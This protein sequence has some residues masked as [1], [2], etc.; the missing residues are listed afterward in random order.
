[1]ARERK[2]KQK[3]GQQFNRGGD[4]NVGLDVPKHNETY[5]SDGNDNVLDENRNIE[6]SN[7]I[8]NDANN[9]G[10]S[11]DGDNGDGDNSDGIVNNIGGNDS[12]DG[13]NHNET[14]SG[15]GNDNV[16]G[17]NRKK[18][19]KTFAMTIMLLVRLVMVTMVMVTTVIALLTI[20]VALTAMML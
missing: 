15:N 13:P 8:C 11:C 5:C 7:D 3:T 10:K 20:L 4:D 1:M 9:V 12:S 6:G 2:K 17:G 16:L 18:E 14:I 19:A